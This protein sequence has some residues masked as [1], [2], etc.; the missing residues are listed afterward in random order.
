MTIEILQ[1]EEENKCSSKQVRFCEAQHLVLIAC[2]NIKFWSATSEIAP[3]HFVCKILFNS[4]DLYF[5]KTT[6]FHITARP[7]TISPW[8][9][10]CLRSHLFDW[11]VHI[12]ICD[13][14]T[15]EFNSNMVSFSINTNPTNV[16]IL[17][18]EAS[19]YQSNAL[20]SQ[21]VWHVLFKLSSVHASPDFYMI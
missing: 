13:S 4:P 11:F 21:V 10:P 7:L 18:L 16:T 12:F 2:D 17:A 6:Q 9:F 3:S 15:R 14:L 8:V 1:F 19:R 5:E 20:R